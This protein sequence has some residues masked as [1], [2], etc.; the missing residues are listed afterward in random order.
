MGLFFHN[1]FFLEAAT[2]ARTRRRLGSFEAMFLMVMVAL[3]NTGSIPE[4]VVTLV[5]NITIVS[6]LTST[7]QIISAKSVRGTSTFMPTLQT[8]TALLSIWTSCGPL[9]PNKPELNTR[10]MIRKHLSLTSA[11]L[12][13]SKSSVEVCC[14][15]SQ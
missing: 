2:W 10:R 5:D 11:V 15:N 14:P 9:F 4:V 7:I 1:D 3:V 12:V 13:T 8:S 6:T